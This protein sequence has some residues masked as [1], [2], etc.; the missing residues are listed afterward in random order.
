MSS[1]IAICFGNRMWLFGQTATTAERFDLVVLIRL[2][3]ISSSEDA[4][5]VRKNFRQ[6]F[7]TLLERDPD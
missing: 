3:I 7:L 1:S 6:K 2:V 4:Q 5:I